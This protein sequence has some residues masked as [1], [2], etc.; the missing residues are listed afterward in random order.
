MARHDVGVSFLLDTAFLTWLNK[1][2]GVAVAFV[3]ALVVSPDGTLWFVRR[4]RTK[5]SRWRRRHHHGHLELSG[6]ATISTAG[7]AVVIRSWR[8][9]TPT[10]EQLEKLRNWIID[11]EHS[12]GRVKS[13]LDKHKTETKKALEEAAS[14]YEVGLKELRSLIQQMEASEARIDGRALPV[15]GWG[16][17]LSGIPELLAKSAWATYPLCLVGIVAMFLVSMSVIRDYLRG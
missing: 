17:L 9:D 3:G 4:L 2:T 6:T 12:I 15:I 11:V 16:I 13:D 7:Y 5:L 14:K 1:G 8:E 10:K